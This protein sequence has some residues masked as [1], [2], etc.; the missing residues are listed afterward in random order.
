MLPD[1]RL[2]PRE[3][4]LAAC[5]LFGH[6]R[7]VT[8][9]GEL[10]SGRAREDDPH[11]P[12]IAWLGGTV[13][14]PEYWARVWGARGLL[15]LGPPADPA[16]V[17]AALD[18]PAWRVREM[19]LKVIAAHDLEDPLGHVDSCTDD[20]VARVRAQAWRVLGMPPSL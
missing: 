15:H 13:G 2:R 6:Q 9:C 5:E 11:W 10:L 4:A 12:D 17:L 18:D 3:R 8:W 20:P 19:A 7:V 14:W 16:I 1:S